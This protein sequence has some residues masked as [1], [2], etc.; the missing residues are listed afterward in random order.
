MVMVCGVLSVLKLLSFRLYADNLINNFSAAVNDY[1]AIDTEEKRTI[2]RRHAFMGRMIC[3]I[4]IFVAYLAA[5]IFM[6]MP[7]IGDEKDILVNVSIT[8][9]NQ[10]SKL[11]VPLTWALGDF[12][13]P[14]SLFLLISM[15]EYMLM[16]LN[17]TSNIGNKQLQLISKILVN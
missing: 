14:T 7:M 8:D 12:N 4:I 13:I 3:C 11:P 15:V 5:T 16:M 9:K 1:L 6:L 10:A 2:I 17:C